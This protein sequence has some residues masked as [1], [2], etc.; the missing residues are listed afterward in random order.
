MGC[1]DCTVV[2]IRVLQIVFAALNLGI[3]AWIVYES[4]QAQGLANSVLTGLDEQKWQDFIDSFLQVPNRVYVVVSVAIWTLL[5]TLFLVIVPRT[6]SWSRLPTGYRYAAWAEGLTL[7]LNFAA[8]ILTITLAIE[9]EPACFVA[10]TAA[11]ELLDALKVCPVSKVAV[12]S[13][14]VSWPLWFFTAVVACCAFRK[15]K[16]KRARQDGNIRMHDEIQTP[17][18]AKPMLETKGLVDEERGN[19]IMITVRTLGSQQPAQVFS[20]PR[21][22]ALGRTGRE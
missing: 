22:G 21:K 12:V 17:E 11:P 8:F 19:D 15:D 4:E 3:G 6:K 13:E 20:M 10:D 9:I 5:T 1:R 16:R 7:C 2:S 14:A 18:S